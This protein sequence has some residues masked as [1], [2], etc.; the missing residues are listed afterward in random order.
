MMPE[1][2]TVAS[3]SAV[4]VISETARFAIEAELTVSSVES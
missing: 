4:P 3:K 1:P 2:T